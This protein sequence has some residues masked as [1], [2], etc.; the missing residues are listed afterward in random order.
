MKR[1]RSFVGFKLFG[2][3]F[4]SMAAV[5]LF[6]S[7]LRETQSEEAWRASFDQ[8]GRQT[9][10]VLERALNYGM[11]LGKKEGVRAA[12]TR[13]GRE[14][15]VQGIR[16]YDKKGKIVFSSNE[17]EVDQVLRKADP[18]CATCH[19]TENDGKPPLLQG[20]A[21]TYRD[22]SGRLLMGNIHLIQNS[23]ECSN[24]SCHEHAPEKTTLGVL[25]LRMRMDVVDEG[26]RA[27]GK[28]TFVTA[29]WMALVGGLVTALFIWAFVRRP[30]QS[31]IQ[32]TREVAQADFHTRLA[33]RGAGEFS[34]I[35]DAFNL[36]T[37]DLEK[38]REK[39]A[40]WEAE[41]E[42]RVNEKTEELGRAHK[43]L[44]QMEKMASLGKLSATVAHEINNPLAGI[45]VYAKLIERELGAGEL[46]AESRAETQ[47]YVTVIRD[48]STR[49]GEIVKNLL[50]FARASRTEKAV[51]SLREIVDRSVATVQH[52]I[53][54]AAVEC[55][56]SSDLESDLVVC[57]KNQ[58]QQ[59]LV[60]LLVNAVEAMPSGG[61]LDIRLGEDSPDAI[62]LTVRDTGIG[63]PT[64]VLPHV[65]EPF[66]TTK[67][68][69]GVGLGLSVVYGIVRRHDGQ[70]EVESQV[71]QGTT[72]RIV[73]PR[74]EERPHETTAEPAPA[75]PASERRS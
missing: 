73:L 54:H 15:G 46:S 36:M 28:N 53:K 25:D 8:H 26:R 50:T 23:K 2:S 32:G 27:A 14:P 35:A 4:V 10:T 69:K 5:F 42:A 67:E 57:D 17:K 75:G 22:D 70:I 51:S 6:F 30:V 58:I 68:E 33:V 62:C 63:I 48:E 56:V 49:C 31:L 11:L 52:L 24:A 19:A 34:E 55:R 16:I 44:L 29:I 21:W 39:T 1:L 74:R 18:A 38:A 13:L 43:K 12:L 66:V 3:I 72:F 9:T 47:R 61:E 20:N 40:R 64:E 65:F 71:N 59:A 41:L 37:A 7:Y 45:L 60:A